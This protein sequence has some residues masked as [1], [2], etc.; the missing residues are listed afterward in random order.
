MQIQIHMKHT[1]IQIHRLTTFLFETCDKTGTIVTNIVIT[2]PSL[3]SG[4]SMIVVLIVA[5]VFTA[6]GSAQTKAFYE[7]IPEEIYN[8]GTIIF[9]IYMCRK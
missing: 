7:S 3:V 2:L 1:Y 8:F 4:L 5:I 9:H 6:D